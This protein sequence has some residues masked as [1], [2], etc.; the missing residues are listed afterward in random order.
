MEDKPGGNVTGAPRNALDGSGN[1][2]APGLLKHSSKPKTQ[3]ELEE[4]TKELDV[5]HLQNR[6]SMGG[7]VEKTVNEKRKGCGLWTRVKS[8]AS[9]RHGEKAPAV[10]FL[11]RNRTEEVKYTPKRGTD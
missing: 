10:G 7:L 3:L 4:R 1:V 6:E 8:S 2:K 9:A 5:T 11:K